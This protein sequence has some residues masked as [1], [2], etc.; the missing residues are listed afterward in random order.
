MGCPI[1]E[2]TW[3]INPIVIMTENYTQNNVQYSLQLTGL[4]VDI[5]KFV[6]EKI[7]LTALFL[8]P[9]LNLELDS[10]IKRAAE[11]EDCSYDPNRYN[12][13]NPCSFYIII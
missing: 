7:N 11:L 9:S 5:V 12:S 3:R 2:G 1:K 4:S 8:A 13:S 6:C 10:C